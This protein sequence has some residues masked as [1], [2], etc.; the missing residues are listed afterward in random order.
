MT[1]GTSDL[2]T[3]ENLD[4][5]GNIIEEHAT[6]P[7]VVTRSGVFGDVS[8][9]GQHRVDHLVVRHV[10]IDSIAEPDMPT[11]AGSFFICLETKEVCPIIKKARLEAR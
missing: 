10:R 9:G 7:E 1:L 8:I 4:G 5:V 3:E 2:V 6:I 11:K